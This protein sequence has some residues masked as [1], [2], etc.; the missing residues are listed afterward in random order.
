MSW[1]PQC[2][3]CHA[4]ETAW[5]TAGREAAAANDSS[6]RF[7]TAA[8]ATATS[9][10][11][12][13]SRARAAARSSRLSWSFHLS[14][15]AAALTAPIHPQNNHP[16]NPAQSKRTFKGRCTAGTKVSHVRRGVRYTEGPSQGI[17]HKRP[18]ARL[19]HADTTRQSSLTISQ[20]DRNVFP[21]PAPHAPPLTP[22]VVPLQ[23]V[24]FPLGPLRLQGV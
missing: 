22:T 7:C 13:D 11:R 4:P 2:S 9:V 3:H 14:P 19:R 23:R 20:P 21:A 17:M 8:A 24:F 5:S 16:Y 18:A 12:A 1:E 6:S 15:Q 10:S